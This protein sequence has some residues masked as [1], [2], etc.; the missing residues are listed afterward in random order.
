MRAI[1]LAVV[2]AITAIA[3][4]TLE[5]QGDTITLT[6]GHPS[7]NG[8]VYK[9]HLAG[10]EVAVMKDGAVLRKSDYT[11]DTHVRQVNGRSVFAVVSESAP[12]AGVK[13]FRLETDLDL[14]TLAL[15]RR[16]DRFADGRHLVYDVDG[17]H[18]TG[19]EV[20]A[21]GKDTTRVDVTL[22]TP[23]YLFAFLDAAVGATPIKAGQIFRIPT[24][25]LAPA[26]RVTEWHTYRVAAREPI[27]SRDGRTLQAW[28]IAEDSTPRYRSR[29]IWL[30]HE[31]P[32]LP[33]IETA[34]LDGSVQVFES[35][36][37]K[38]P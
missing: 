8:R 5:A 17:A 33:R 22:E 32:Y 36:L 4:L 12:D 10:V 27:K 6:V 38:R 23:S 28:V 18:L 29:K 3:P 16:E 34:M 13:G 35:W 21:G 2:L 20:G 30:T 1:R 11:N 15:V 14:R 31:A 24:F 7:V 37:M 26:R 9:D 25:D 19:T